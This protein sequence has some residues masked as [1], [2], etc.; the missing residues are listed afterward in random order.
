VQ[1]TIH[2]GFNLA[3]KCVMLLLAV[4]TELI[5]HVLLVCIITVSATAK[6]VIVNFRFCKENK[7][8]SLQC[9][10]INLSKFKLQNLTE[11]EIRV[12]RFIKLTSNNIQE[13]WHSITR[14]YCT[15]FVK[16]IFFSRKWLHYHGCI[17][18]ITILLDTVLA[19]P[20]QAKR[21]IHQSL[22]MATWQTGTAIFSS[23]SSKLLRDI[24]RHLKLVIG[25]IIFSG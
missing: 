2:I 22:N 15:N 3:I 17:M 10:N 7:T 8:A 14:N 16:S 24:S 13:N 11:E 4:H 23:S 25:S 12:F 18:H 9:R 19:N 21:W 5:T 20:V 1:W 6:W